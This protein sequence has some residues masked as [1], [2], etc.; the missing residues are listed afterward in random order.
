MLSDVILAEQLDT[1]FV[2]FIVGNPK[3]IPKLFCNA[4]GVEFYTNLT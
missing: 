4:D 3:L 2:I 1:E